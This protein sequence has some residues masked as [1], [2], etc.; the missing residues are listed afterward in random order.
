MVS[1]ILSWCKSDLVR[2]IGEIGGWGGGPKYT[3]LVK[4][5]SCV[6]LGGGVEI[7]TTPT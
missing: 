6:E 2:D 3:Y 5:E 7:Q 4:E 1:T